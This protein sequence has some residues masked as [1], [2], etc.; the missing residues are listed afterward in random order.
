MGF[1]SPRP[2]STCSR[3]LV[4]VAFVT[5]PCMNWGWN[6]ACCFVS[7]RFTISRTVALGPTIT[8]RCPGTVTTSDLVKEVGNGRLL[9]RLHMFRIFWSDH[10]CKCL[11]FTGSVS[12]QV[13]C[14]AAR[15]ETKTLEALNPPSPSCSCAGSGSCQSRRPASWAC[16]QSHTWSERHG[17]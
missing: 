15:L 12:C 9:R 3:S 13:R 4:P 1:L 8:T 17:G 2:S 14:P 6:R 7:V 5:S 10:S 11:D 16:P